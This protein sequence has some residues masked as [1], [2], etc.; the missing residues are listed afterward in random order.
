[1]AVNAIPNPKKSNQ[2]DFPIEKVKLSVLNISLRNNKYKFSKANEIFNQDTFESS[3][4]L[5]LGV[6][7]DINLNKITE[8]KTEIIVEIR[9]K[10]GK[11]NQSY[12]ITIA[13]VHIEKT[14]EYLAFLITKSPEEIEQYKANQILSKNIKKHHSKF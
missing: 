10:I 2:V 14:F 4:F 1:M 3:E 7:F 11:F 6:Y 8:G 12:E 5:S 9:R 13:N